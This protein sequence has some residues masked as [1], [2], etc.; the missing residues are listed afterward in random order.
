MFPRSLSLPLDG[1]ESMFIFGPRG[2]GKTHWLKH[3]LIDHEHVYIDL[4]D[5]FM[6]RH[7]QAYPEKLSEFFNPDKA[8]WIVIDEV[9]KVPELLDEVHRQIEHHQRKFILT[10]SSA[11]KLKQKGVNLLAGRAIH[12]HRQVPLMQRKLHEKWE[13]R[14]R[15]YKIIFQFCTIYS[16]HGI[17]PHLQKKL[18]VD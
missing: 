3:H 15:L 5:P 18:N 6:F 12:Y 8:A 9:Q 7:L 14:E 17:Y 11:R 16:Y 10:G 1:K 4:L 13:L 2:T